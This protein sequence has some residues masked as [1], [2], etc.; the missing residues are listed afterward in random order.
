M[1]RFLLVYSRWRHT[2]N[3]QSKLIVR[4]RLTYVALYSLQHIHLLLR[5]LDNIIN[6]LSLAKCPTAFTVPLWQ[7]PASTQC[8]LPNLSE[9]QIYHH[10]DW[11][12]GME[13][14]GS[15]MLYAEVYASSI[16]TACYSLGICT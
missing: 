4:P 5:V 16:I 13:D 6:Q 10:Y 7:F 2:Q 14:L 15:R 3:T 1:D 11:C 8:A 12:I 9:L